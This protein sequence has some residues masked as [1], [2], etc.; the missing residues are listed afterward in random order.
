MVAGR[1]PFKEYVKSPD[2][3]GNCAKVFK[4]FL[5][6]LFPIEHLRWLSLPFAG[7]LQNRFY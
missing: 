2:G 3:L 6:K 5:R 7:V 1:D 4:K